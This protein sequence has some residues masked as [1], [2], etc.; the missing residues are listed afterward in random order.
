MQ[1]KQVSF[2]SSFSVLIEKAA[3]GRAFVVTRLL[4][5]ARCLLITGLLLVP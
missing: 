1:I 2:E 5:V 3:Q 4:L